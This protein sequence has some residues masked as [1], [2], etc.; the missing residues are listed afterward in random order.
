MVFS[1]YIFKR[2]RTFCDLA[3]RSFGENILRR[4]LSET[5]KLMAMIYSIVLKTRTGISSKMS[6]IFGYIVHIA[7]ELLS[8]KCL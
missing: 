4:F 3:Y 7:L 1:R 2:S 5:N 6:F 8:L